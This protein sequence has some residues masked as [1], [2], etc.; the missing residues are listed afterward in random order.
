VAKLDSILAGG[1]EHK[2]FKGSVTKLKHYFQQAKTFN[3]LY[4]STAVQLH[5]L[6]LSRLPACFTSLLATTN[7]MTSKLF[8]SSA[9]LSLIRKVVDVVSDTIKAELSF[10]ECFRRREL[11][12]LLSVREGFEVLLG[13][14]LSTKDRPKTA[15][16]TACEGPTRPS[17]AASV[18]VE[19]SSL[20]ERA[21]Y[22][23]R[24]AWDL[25]QMIEE[26]S[27]VV[28]CSPLAE[29]L[30]RIYEHTAPEFD[31]WAKA[32]CLKWELLIKNFALRLRPSVDWTKEEEDA[33]ESV[34]WSVS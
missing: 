5:S 4:G 34:S 15:M 6:E 2:H 26:Y 9:K 18:G 24:V 28:R 33:E 14:N 31:I 21:A 13:S 7:L 27:E 12:K 29:E 30:V 19:S 32:N 22:F 1:K 3:Q 8:D 16:T 20:W 11:S 17:T 25:I 23:M 10:N